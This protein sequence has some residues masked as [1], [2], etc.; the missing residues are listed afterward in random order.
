M[1]ICHNCQFVEK[2]EI[3]S[4]AKFVLVNLLSLIVFYDNPR[5]VCHNGFHEFCTVPVLHLASDANF[6]EPVGIF[7][8]IV[9]GTS[10]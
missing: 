1:S 3:Q 6:G 9:N 7:S 5:V 2:V 8:L 4:F 10:V